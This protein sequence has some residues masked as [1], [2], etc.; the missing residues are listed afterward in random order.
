M[1]SCQIACPTLMAF[2]GLSAAVAQS[3]SHAVQERTNSPYGLRVYEWDTA[4]HFL[5]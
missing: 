3:A 4:W 1:L 5:A 2:Q